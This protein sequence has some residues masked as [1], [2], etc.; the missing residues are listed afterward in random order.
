MKISKKLAL[1]VWAQMFGDKEFA[2]D[3]DGGLMYKGAYGDTKYYVIKDDVKIYCGW[4]LH[5]ILPK[6][7]NGND[8]FNNL[9]CTN[10]LTNKTIGNKTTY[11]IDDRKYQVKRIKGTNRYEIYQLY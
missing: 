6:A 9:I 4:N 8:S 1:K 11:W 2:N 10:I 7:C 3:F 5:H